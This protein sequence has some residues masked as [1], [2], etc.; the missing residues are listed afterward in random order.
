MHEQDSVSD[1]QSADGSK[2]IGSPNVPWAIKCAR[3]VMGQHG[4][5][6]LENFRFSQSLCVLQQQQQAKKCSSAMQK[7]C[8]QPSKRCSEKISLVGLR[9]S[10]DIHSQCYTIGEGFSFEKPIAGPLPEQLPPLLLL[11]I[12]LNRY[13][14]KAPD[15]RIMKSNPKCTAMD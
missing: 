9:T 12:E 4:V 2:L 14:S 6:I 7:L 8:L 13:S 15:H 3:R 5:E 1:E 10:C 11:D